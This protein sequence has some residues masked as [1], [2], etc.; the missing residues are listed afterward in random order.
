MPASARQH[1]VA[2][3]VPL[4]PSTRYSSSHGYTA[5]YSSNDNA[6]RSHAT[7][8]RHHEVDGQQLQP[9]YSN[10]RRGS[11]CQAIMALIGRS[12]AD[13]APQA[14]ADARRSRLVATDA[15]PAAARRPPPERRRQH[16]T[17]PPPFRDEREDRQISRG[18]TAISQPVAPRK[19]KHTQ[20]GSGADIFQW[21]SASTRIQRIEMEAPERRGT[22]R[23]AS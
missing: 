20:A 5:A 13:S 6:T 12:E 7:P 10:P 1:S 22:Y 23:H 9:H 21:C 15:M 17:P 4:P 14:S 8:P 2:Y 3:Q 11:R 19:I 16:H 18:P